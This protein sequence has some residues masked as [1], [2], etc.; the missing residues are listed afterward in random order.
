MERTVFIRVSA[1]A[2]NAAFSKSLAS[3]SHLSSNVGS[4]F[5]L[6]VAPY[7]LPAKILGSDEVGKDIVSRENLRIGLRF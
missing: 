7:F 2:S 6:R 5:M 3:K 1:A 4:P